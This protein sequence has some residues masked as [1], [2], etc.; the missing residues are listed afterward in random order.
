MR[1]VKPYED[2]LECGF[3]AGGFTTPAFR[4]DTYVD[5]I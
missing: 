1:V 5:Y 3:L 2:A 4:S